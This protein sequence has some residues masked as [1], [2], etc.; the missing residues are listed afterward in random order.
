MGGWNRGGGRKGGGFSVPFLGR[1]LPV[2][3]GPRPLQGPRSTG[4]EIA[5]PCPP[6][7]V[8]QQTLRTACAWTAW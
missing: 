6:A 4:Y 2:Q 7:S 1:G 5:I 8:Q 3:G